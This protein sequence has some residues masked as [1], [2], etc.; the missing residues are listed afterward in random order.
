MS[1]TYLIQAKTAK[2]NRET[3]M[4]SVKIIMFFPTAS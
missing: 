2:L 3:A 1:K 4:S